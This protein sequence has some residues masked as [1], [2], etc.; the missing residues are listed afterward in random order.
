M[1]YRPARSPA[2]GKDIMLAPQGS[3]FYHNLVEK[4]LKE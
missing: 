2:K 3:H 4:S 1:L